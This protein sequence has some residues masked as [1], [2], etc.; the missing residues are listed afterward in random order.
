MS[1][2]GHCLHDCKGRD[3]CLTAWKGSTVLV[4]NPWPIRG[5]T[6]AP[7]ARSRLPACLM[8]LLHPGLA[9]PTPWLR[10]SVR[11]DTRQETEGREEAEPSRCSERRPVLTPGS[12][13]WARAPEDP[14]PAPGSVAS[15]GNRAFAEVT[16]SG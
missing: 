12:L 6:R 5:T 2:P 1:Q 8:S 9:V 7:A 16:E 4:A 10:P 3:A 13:G 15:L 11:K 14:A